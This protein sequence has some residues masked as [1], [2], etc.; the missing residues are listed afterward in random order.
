MTRK[1][2][3]RIIATLG[4]PAENNNKSV[5]FRTQFVIPEFRS[6]L[7]DWE[8]WAVNRPMAPPLGWLERLRP[9][10]RRQQRVFWTIVYFLNKY[11]PVIC[12]LQI[13]SPPWSFLGAAP[14]C[15]FY[16]YSILERELIWAFIHSY[17][18]HPKN[19]LSVFPARKSSPWSRGRVKIFFLPPVAPC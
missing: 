8:D 19:G 5:Y 2:P 12:P 1:L 9:P 6:D 7:F 16:A 14:M 10:G 18:S 13:V 15:I 11:N 3:T 4:R 17:S